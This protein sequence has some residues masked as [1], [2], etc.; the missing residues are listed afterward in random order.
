MAQFNFLKK[1]F[2]VAFLFL[3]TSLSW[4]QAD[5]VGEVVFAVGTTNV[6][7]GQKLYPKNELTTGRDGHIHVRFIDNGFVS[8]RPN[9]RLTIQEYRYDAQDSSL[10]KVKFDLQNGTVR[11]VTG[12]SGQ[13]NKSGFRMNTPI[14]AIGIR[15]TDFTVEA[16]LNSSRVFVAN[17]GIAIAPFNDQCLPS[18]SGACHN[19]TEL[20]AKDQKILELQQSDSHIILKEIQV[21]LPAV[22]VNGENETETEP[23]NGVTTP[24]ELEDKTLQELQLHS[25]LDDGAIPKDNDQQTPMQ[26]ASWG[27]WTGLADELGDQYL[28][29]QELAANPDL[30][31]IG[32]TSSMGIFAPTDYSYPEGNGK[33]GFELSEY[34]AWSKTAGGVQPAQVDGA[35]LTVDFDNKTF[36]TSLQVTNDQVD[37][38]VAASGSIDRIGH[39]AGQGENSQVS[40]SLFNENAQAGY[41]FEKQVTTDS[42]V[43]GATSWQQ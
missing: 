32:L 28:T 11:S 23:Q 16:T 18:G 25:I 9:S 31:I 5:A 27:H 22:E 1:T 8:V 20:F 12:K 40:G 29:L 15:G 26:T 34:V 39:F 17:G 35:E 42:Q 13:E 30:E 6:E 21:S 38:Q 19:A 36:N 2:F 41:V 43:F 24:N 14:A 4:A 33:I 3:F 37:T 7:K 10:N